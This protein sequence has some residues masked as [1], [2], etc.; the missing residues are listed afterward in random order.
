MDFHILNHP[1][2]PGIK[3]ILRIVLMYSW[4]QFGRILLSIFASIFIRE[5]GLKFSFFVVT[6]Y[7]FG[8]SITVAS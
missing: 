6:L 5:I 8:I 2:I 7:G 3:P 1:R 4:I